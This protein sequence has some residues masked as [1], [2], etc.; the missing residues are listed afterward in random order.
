MVTLEDNWQELSDAEMHL[1]SRQTF[2]GWL[3]H[4]SAGKN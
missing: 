2:A 4:R 1:Y 3:G